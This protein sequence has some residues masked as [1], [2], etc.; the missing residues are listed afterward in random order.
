M[1]SKTSA[2]FTKTPYEAIFPVATETA[3]GVASPSAHGHDITS[4][5]TALEKAKSNGFPINSQTASVIIEISVT[6]GT[7]MPLT[8]SAKR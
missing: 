4:T 3:T 1:R 8:L 2:F 7:K 5:D 6:V